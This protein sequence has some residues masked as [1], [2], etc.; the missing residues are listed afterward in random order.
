MHLI[1]H[2]SRLLLSEGT[3]I[4]DWTFQLSFILGPSKKTYIY[5]QQTGHVL[6]AIQN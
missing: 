1:Y 2:K 5:I 4:Y 6:R 3:R